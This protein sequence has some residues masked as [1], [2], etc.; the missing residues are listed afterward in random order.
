M[1]HLFSCRLSPVPP[2]C[3]LQ[4]IAAGF[5]DATNVLIFTYYF[6]EKEVSEFSD[7]FLSWVRGDYPT[8]RDLG[9]PI[10]KH[11]IYHI[12][13]QKTIPEA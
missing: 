12:T 8:L 1:S 4:R 10:Y 3:V 6:V 7:T 5:T 13:R 11:L 9:Q 2:R